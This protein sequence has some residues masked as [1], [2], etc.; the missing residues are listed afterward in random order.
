MHRQV[1]EERAPA[2]VEHPHDPAAGERQ[3]QPS[4]R[5]ELDVLDR[6]AGHE[7]VRLLAPR[8][9]PDR[10]GSIH[11]PGRGEGA[12]SAHRH[13]R[14]RR[15]AAAERVHEGAAVRPP[16]AN[17]PVAIARHDHRPARAV[18]GARDPGGAEAVDDPSRARVEDAGAAIGARQHEPRAVGAEGGDR[19]AWT[20]PVDH[21]PGR[22]ADDG[23]DTRSEE[24]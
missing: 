4:V 19:C 1:G 15:A 21:G 20:G 6:P 17:R 14:D 3:Q 24:R 2:R 11:R 7:D 9:P 22:R 18:D 8:E 16:E 12:V 23:P 5:A 10:H 13:V